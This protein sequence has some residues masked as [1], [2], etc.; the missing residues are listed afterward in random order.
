MPRDP[1]LSHPSWRAAQAYW[2]GELRR[3]RL[4]CQATRCKDPGRPIERGG[5]RGPWHLDVGHVVSR[6]QARDQGWN[7]EQANA[8]GNTRPE[9]ATCSHSTGATEGNQRRWGTVVPDPITSGV[10]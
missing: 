6:A 5:Q 10:W 2:R 4:H 1:W 9:H 3:R 7:V 8:L